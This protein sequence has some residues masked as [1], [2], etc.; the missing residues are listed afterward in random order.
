MALQPRPATELASSVLSGVACPSSTYCVAVGRQ[1]NDDTSGLDFRQHLLLDVWNGARWSVQRMPR[2]APWQGEELQGVSCASGAC[3]A[4]GSY[5]ANPGPGIE[6]GQPLAERWD[7]R[8]WTV[9]RLSDRKLYFPELT[10]VS[11]VSR[12]FCLAAGR[13]ATSQNVTAAGPFAARWN[14]KHWTE[15][16]AGL[17][18]YAPL[19]SVS[20][21]TTSFC[22]AA[23]Q[24]NSQLLPKEGSSAT[25]IEAWNGSRWDRSAT[26]AVPNPT[27]PELFSYQADNPGLTG[28][29]CLASVGCTAVGA[30]GAGGLNSAPLAQSSAGAP[31]AVAEAPAVPGPVLGRSADVRTVA[32]SV[33]VQLAGTHTFVPLTSLSR[34]PLGTIVDTTNGT[35]QLTSAADAHGHTQTGQFYGGAFRLEQKRVRGQGGQTVEVT[36][37]RLMG[38]ASTECAAAAARSAKTRRRGRAK[39][40]GRS[41]A[42]NFTSET[43]D[44]TAGRNGDPTWLTEETCS[45]TLVK[46][47]Q[48]AVSV[49]NLH[50]RKSVVVR[51]GH[52]LFTPSHASGSPPSSPTP[53]PWSALGGAVE[54]GVTG[55]LPPEL[56]CQSQTGAIPARPDPASEGDPGVVLRATGQPILTGLSEWEPWPWLGSGPLPFTPLAAGSIWRSIVTCSVAE[57]SVRC[58]NASGNGFTISKGSYIPF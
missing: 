11:C 46:V 17:P 13:Y 28:I 25:L 3:M 45:G 50:T 39:L 8:R 38:G 33:S 5:N 6:E 44:V 16:R 10:S 1:E 31:A 18:Q 42:G 23:G 32:G 41:K 9:Q 20:C 40:W 55:G 36:A 30:Q 57:T 27:L 43:S 14:G 2:A 56:L 52:S 35:V 26:P 54:C 49:E 15:A 7:G 34:V 58:S 53:A 24:Y 12:S 37:L 51:A 47:T 19:Y 21:V 22:L 29:S 48:G 4:V